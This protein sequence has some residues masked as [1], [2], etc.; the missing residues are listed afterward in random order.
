MA[1]QSA[2]RRGRAHG[3]PKFQKF[4]ESSC[5][6]SDCRKACT[7]SP[8]WFLPRQVEDLARAMDLSVEELFRRHLAVGVTAMPDGSQRHGVMPHK[9]RDGKK[10][11]AVWTLAELAQPGRCTFFDR[12]RCTIYQHRPFECSRMIHHAADKAVQLRHHIVQYVGRQGAEARTRSGRG[13]GCS[14]R[15]PRRKRRGPA[16]AEPRGEV[17]GRCARACGRRSL[18]PARLP[19]RSPLHRP[20][21]VRPGPHPASS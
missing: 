20:L 2:G 13:R 9:L 4:R 15:R 11:G 5:D 1:P 8:G 18:R 7:Q 17:A 10:P 21:R 16:R 3:A 6:C 12:G 14:G 19:R